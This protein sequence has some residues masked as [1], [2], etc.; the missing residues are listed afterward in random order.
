MATL[1]PTGTGHTSMLSKVTSRYRAK[2]L[3]GHYKKQKE[4]CCKKCFAGVSFKKMSTLG[5]G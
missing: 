3:A 2:F 4:F 5:R 1:G